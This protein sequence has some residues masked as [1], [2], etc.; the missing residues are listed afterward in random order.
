MIPN[1]KNIQKTQC[2]YHTRQVGKQLKKKQKK[3]TTFIS[4]EI[5]CITATVQ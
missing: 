5:L 2:N 1:Q 4:C 3:N